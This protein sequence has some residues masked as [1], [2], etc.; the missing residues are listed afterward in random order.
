MEMYIHIYICVY[1][2]MRVYTYTHVCVRQDK[3]WEETIIYGNIYIYAYI[4]MCLYIHVC[5]YM[6]VCVYTYQ[7]KNEKNIFVY[8]NEEYLNNMQAPKWHGWLLLA[9]QVLTLALSLRF[10]LRVQDADK[11]DLKQRIMVDVPYL[12]HTFPLED[13]LHLHHTSFYL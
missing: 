1:I 6:Y 4:C 10:S 11:K 9:F 3:K 7:D 8:K 13:H 12:E 5:I 2:C